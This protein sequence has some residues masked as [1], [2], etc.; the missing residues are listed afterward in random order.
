[1]HVGAIRVI[2]ERTGI[3]EASPLLIYS[4]VFQIY[5]SQGQLYFSKFLLEFSCWGLNLSSSEPQ[6]PRAIT[7]GD[8]RPAHPCLL[9]RIDMITARD[10][11]NTVGHL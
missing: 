10:S 4:T 3:I 2:A 11:A 5:K 8:T 6:G 7:W 1:M 9:G